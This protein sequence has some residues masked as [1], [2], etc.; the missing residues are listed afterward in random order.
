MSLE[1]IRAAIKI[2][3]FISEILCIV[4]SFG[5]SVCSFLGAAVYLRPR[6][7]CFTFRGGRGRIGTCLGVAQLVARSVRDAEVV[8]SS[9]ITQTKRIKE[10]E[11]ERCDKADND[12]YDNDEIRRVGDQFKEPAKDREAES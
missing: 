1:K 7:L 10:F 12:R 4:S 11:Q 9:L 3:A 8:S 2:A 6:F 5:G